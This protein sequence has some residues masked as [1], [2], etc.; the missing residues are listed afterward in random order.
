MAGDIKSFLSQST[1][2]YRVPYG[3]IAERFKRHSII[4]G[5]S[6]RHDG[7]LQDETG[8]RRFWII[9]TTKSMY[10]PIDVEEVLK[11]RDQIWAAAYNYWLN[12]ESLLL[13]KE[14]QLVVDDETQQYVIESPWRTVIESY[15]D[16][17]SNYAKELTT[18]LIL[19]EAIEK[20]VERQTRYD[21]MQVATILKDLGYDKKRRGPKNCRKWVYI[22]DT[23]GVQPVSLP[24]EGMDTLETI[25]INS[26]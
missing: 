18:E 2:I 25:D 5:T 15:L 22:R 21:Q 10:N 11:R 13:S 23:T 12:D 26:F 1:D 16:S 19:T 6:N 8:N 14:N 9:K 20:P 24:L 17:P 3:K 7:F 4:V